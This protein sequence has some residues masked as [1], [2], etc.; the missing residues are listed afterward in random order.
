MLAVVVLGVLAATV[1]YGT[2][3]HRL[4]LLAQPN[5]VRFVISKVVTVVFL[6]IV[7]ATPTV[8]LAY[9]LAQSAMGPY[10]STL[11]AASVP[12]AVIGA[13]LALALMALVAYGLAVITR[14]SVLPLA[15]LLPLIF[16]GSQILSVIAATSTAAR[17]LPDQA[18][19][20]I[21]RIDPGPG[22]LSSL[23]G[24]VVLVS[25]VFGLLVAAAVLTERRHA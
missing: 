22:E 13:V 6:V 17:Y 1:E 10:G 18:A 2:G 24:L 14:S 4:S 16:A 20:Q 8:P 9:V 25:W 7:V 5:R 21:Y 3:M 11:G 19:M 12:L 23:E 15:I